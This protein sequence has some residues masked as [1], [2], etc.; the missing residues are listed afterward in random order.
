MARKK[1]WDE[2]LEKEYQE[3]RKKDDEELAKLESEFDNIVRQMGEMDNI[4]LLVHYDYFRNP[5]YTDL[6]QKFVYRRLADEAR[7]LIL[8][9]MVKVDDKPIIL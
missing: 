4:H 5:T 7:E 6:R 9:R 1:N 2:V 8:A 3:S